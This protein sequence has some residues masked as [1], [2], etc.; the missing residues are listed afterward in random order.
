MLKILKTRKTAMVAAIFLVI[1]ILVGIFADFVAPYDVN[2]N[3]VPDRYTKPFKQ[4]AVLDENGQETG[5]MEI[6]YLLGTDEFGRDVFSQMCYGARMTLICALGV[7][8]LS[9]VTGTVFG[10][11]A[12]YFKTAGALIMRFIDAMMAF[13][14]IMLAMVLVVALGQSA[15]CVIVAVGTYFMT[16][17]T[18]IVYGLTLSLKEQTYIEAAKSQGVNNSRIVARHIFPNLLSPIIVQA[19]FTFSSSILQMASLDYLGLGVSSEHPTWG[20]LL[21]AGKSVMM[22]APWMVI[23]PGIIIVLTVLSL[24][25]IGDVM[26]DNSDPKFRDIL[27]EG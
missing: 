24:N 15:F 13:P 5:K 4:T 25:V 23:V 26:R 27:K 9:L 22:I 11:I 20:G 8:V 18:R 16:R 6:K 7:V 10:L 19:T 21:N 2:E 14:P 17:M 12:G 1:I 3:H